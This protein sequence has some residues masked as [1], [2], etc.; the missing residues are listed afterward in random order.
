MAFN[1]FPYTDGHELNLD[2]VIKTYKDSVKNALDAM[3]LSEETKAYVNDYFS[4]LDVQEE[5]NNKL[6]TMPIYQSVSDILRPSVIAAVNSY[7]AD[8]FDNPDSPP[9]DDTLSVHGAAA[10]AF[11]TGIVAKNLSAYNSANILN[12][13]GSY[14][15]RDHQGVQFTVHENYWIPSYDVN[16]ATSSLSAFVNLINAAT[17]PTGSN[18][19][20]GKHLYCTVSSSNSNILYMAVFFYVN[21]S[22]T[23]K[24]IVRTSSEIII[25][26]NAT[27]LLARVEAAENTTFVD[28]SISCVILTAPTNEA[29]NNKL[30]SFNGKITSMAEQGYST[31]PVNLSEVITPGFYLFDDS[32]TITDN[33]RTIPED[34]TRARYLIVERT[35]TTWTTAFLIQRFGSLNTNVEYKS[36]KGG[37]VTNW[38]SFEAAGG[39]IN[40]NYYTT[41]YNVTAT[42]SIT[43]NNNNYL[44]STGDTTDRSADI[45]A[46]LSAGRY[47]KLGPGDFYVSN[48][49]LTYGCTLEGSG[50]STQIVMMDSVTAGNAITM[51]SASTVRNLKVRGTK[52]TPH[53]ATPAGSRNG[54]VVEYTSGQGPIS[55]TMIDNVWIDSFNGAGLMCRNSGISPVNGLVACNLNISQ[56]DIGI[57]IPDYSEYH[58]FTNCNIHDNYLGCSVNT[59]N[60]QFVNCNI[61]GN[62]MGVQMDGSN[63]QN[64]GHG[65]FI[66][67]TI[68]HSDSNNGTAI[69]L[70]NIDT[71]EIFSG[72]NIHYGKINMAGCKN[73]IMNSCILGFTTPITI[74]S[75]IGVSFDS[76]HCSA[77]AGSSVTLTSSPTTRFTNCVK[78]DGAIWSPV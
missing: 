71:G 58:S 52:N 51:R 65:A 34:V 15:S 16:G 40:N 48:I 37:P 66:G 72:C 64:N 3:E 68:N 47:C 11:K 32:W 53:P 21:G 69:K 13:Y 74:T 19:Y 35:N 2:W 22:L 54:I 76:C 36:T 50:L 57:S 38:S 42:P 8:N 29:I 10:D 49:N 75:C 24:T 60:N 26:E 23:G 43:Y 41:T 62:I 30:A 18:L 44:P 27:G 55:Y 78:G 14:T 63:Y 73:I 45:A 31:N 39:E 46:M 17:W 25:P 67:C 56:N 1:N 9:V 20:A 6:D 4:N 7:L 12:L 77:T 59:G 28:Q 5:I 33:T 61:S 70:M